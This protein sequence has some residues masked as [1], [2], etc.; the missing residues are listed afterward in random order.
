MSIIKLILKRIFLGVVLALT[1][2]IIGFSI[3][4]NMR[5]SG[6][7]SINTFLLAWLILG[8]ILF[9][10]TPMKYALI[11]TVFLGI[12][13]DLFSDIGDVPFEDVSLDTSGDKGSVLP[14][15]EGDVG[16]HFVEPHWVE[17]YYRDDGTY[18]EGYWRDG[19]GNPSTNLT[20]NQGGG[21]VRSNPDGNPFNNLNN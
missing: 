5:G 20:A 17:S 15:V 6:D 21:Y 14:V 10:Y 11:F 4:L 3:F 7:S 18:V 13:A 2:L 16:T 12:G 8:V 19:D 1:Y 9:F